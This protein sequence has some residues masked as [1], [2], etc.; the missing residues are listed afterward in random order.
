MKDSGQRCQHRAQIMCWSLM[1]F[2]W[3]EPWIAV[4]ANL[5]LEDCRTIIAAQTT[6]SLCILASPK[7]VMINLIRPAGH[8]KKKEVD[9]LLKSLQLSCFNSKLTGM[10]E[11]A[12]SECTSLS[13]LI[14]PEQCCSVFK[15]VPTYSV[16]WTIILSMCVFCKLHYK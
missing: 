9:L 4:R 11:S 12:G 1:R 3:N 10:C 13:A 8:V 2:H 15:R 6:L 16:T 14:D 7:F 5:T